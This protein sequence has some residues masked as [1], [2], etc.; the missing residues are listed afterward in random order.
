MWLAVRGGAAQGSLILVVLGLLISVPIVVWGST[1]IL[2]WVDRF[3]ALAYLGAGVP[4]VDGGADDVAR[5]PLLA[6]HLA[7]SEAHQDRGLCARDRGASLA[8]VF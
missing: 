3:P 5:K 6:P 4:R 7:G 8:S 1:L 2:G